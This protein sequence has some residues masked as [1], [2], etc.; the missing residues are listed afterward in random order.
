MHK[1]VRITITDGMGRVRV[2]EDDVNPTERTASVAAH[3]L[4]DRVVLDSDDTIRVTFLEPA[5]AHDFYNYA[6]VEARAL[7]AGELA[8]LKP[9]A[10]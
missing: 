1:R 2:L 7:A 4:L 8:L 3:D 10:E 6:D 9:Q 5:Y